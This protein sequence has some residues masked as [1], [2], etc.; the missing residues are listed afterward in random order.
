MEVHSPSRCGGALL[1]SGAVTWAQWG[2]A[3]VWC[4]GIR[5]ICRGGYMY[6]RRSQQRL[7]FPGKPAEKRASLR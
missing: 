5:Y 7:G 6:L 2:P 4:Q 3:C 1:V